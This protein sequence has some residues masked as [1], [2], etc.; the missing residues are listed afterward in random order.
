VA[1][2]CLRRRAAGESLTDDQILAA[3]PDIAAELAEELA[4]ARLIGQARRTADE[5]PTMSEASG[6]PLTS[7]AG[8]AGRGTSA[9]GDATAGQAGRG[10]PPGAASDAE[11]EGLPPS[12]FKV[13]GYSIIR[14]ISRGGQAVVFEAL[15]ESTGRK[16]AVKVLREGPFL[17]AR[18]RARFDREVQI[19]AAL[20]HP[21]IVSIIDRGATEHGAQY[22][23]MDYIE[24]RTLDQYLADYRDKHGDAPLDPSQML[25]LFLKI[26]DAVNAAHL[27]GIV[28]RDLKPS[29]IRIDGRGEPHILDFGLA[30]VWAVRSLTD[31]SVPQPVTLTGQFLGSLPWA[32]PEQAEGLPDKIDIRSDVYSLGVVLYQMLTGGHFPYEVA[33]TMR[34]VL[35]NIITVAPTPPSQMIEAGLARKMRGRRGRFRRRKA[36][37][38]VIEAIVLKSLAKGP[39]QRYQS[40]GDFARDIGNYLSGQPTIAAGMAALRRQRRSRLVRA[41]AVAGGIVAACLL[42]AVVMLTVILPR[43]FAPALPEAPRGAEEAALAAR[44]A[45]VAAIF[46]D[47]D[48]FTVPTA[49]LGQL[50]YVGIVRK[51]PGILTIGQDGILRLW[52]VLLENERRR[53]NLDLPRWWHTGHFCI[54]PDGALGFSTEDLGR[55]LERS[56]NLMN[57]AGH[58]W[59]LARGTEVK[60]VSFGEDR[61]DRGPTLGF[62][63]DGRFVLSVLMR[64]PLGNWLAILWNANT[65]EQVAKFR[66]E[67]DVFAFSQDMRLLVLGDGTRDLPDRLRAIDL[68]TRQ[69][70]KQFKGHK[71]PVGSAAVSPDGRFILGGGAASDP[72][73][74]QWDAATGDIVRRFEGHTGDVTAVAMSADGRWVLSSSAADSDNTLRIWDAQTGREVRRWPDAGADEI[75]LPPDRPWAMT[76]RGVTVRLYRLPTE[77]PTTATPLAPPT[78]PA[79]PVP[80]P[81]VAPPNTLTDAEKA[82]GWRLLFDGKTLAGWRVPQKNDLPTAWSVVDGTLFTDRRVVPMITQDQFDNFEL[83]LEWKI[84]GDGE[85]VLTYRATEDHLN[86]WM[87][88]PSVSLADDEGRD[89]KGSSVRW[90]G[91]CH[92]LYAPAQK[93]ARPAG[94]WNR[95]RVVA[96]GNKVEHWVNGVK[97]LEYE[98]GSE[99]FRQRLAK[100]AY[101]E[102]WAGFGTAPRGHIGLCSVQPVAV[103]FRNIKIRPLGA[104]PAAAAPPSAVPETL[105]GPG[106]WVDVLALVDPQRDTV[107]GEWQRQG[108]T[109][110]VSLPA[111]KWGCVVIPVAPGGDYELEVRFVRLSGQDEVGVSLPVGDAA[112]NFCLSE[113]GGVTGGLGFINGKKICDTE[114]AVNPSRLENGREYVVHVKVASDGPNATIEVA[115]DGKPYTAWRG[116]RAAL[117]RD[118]EKRLPRHNCLGLR[119][120]GSTVAFF[121]ARLRML[122]GAAMLLGSPPAAAPAPAA[123]SQMGPTIGPGQWVDLL[124]LVDPSADA[125]RGKWER[126]DGFLL[127]QGGWY[128]CL[129]LPVVVDGSYE[130]SVSA[131]DPGGKAAYVMVLLPVGASCTR[132]QCGAF[133]RSPAL[134]AGPKPAPE[135][136]LREAP[137]AGAEC[138]ADVKVVTDRDQGEI[139]ALT[140]GKPGLHWK[141]RQADLGVEALWQP[142]RP[143][144]PGLCAHGEPVLYTSAKLRMLS[145]EARLLRP[146]PDPAAK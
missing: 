78:T 62:S 47:K 61:S 74:I 120:V 86:P 125:T 19:L 109:V 93:A 100:W 69:E 127:A 103:A 137:V 84:A 105:V 28:H 124:A 134:F 10:K 129:L 106:Q 5:A 33:G 114:T 49:R 64:P 31:E 98:L 131:R 91:G 55:T 36:V 88:G 133:D 136:L 80:P 143:F 25:R 8:Q 138:R 121:S 46:G 115:L 1:E 83:D 141:G 37:N 140:D 12:S 73:V 51:G 90:S 26:A 50:R 9:E 118:E 117:S 11:G 7:T 101:G 60:V 126:R 13:P 102:I 58:F 34:D 44:E 24:G 65:G 76:R 38:E 14:E 110:S 146:P 67:R 116:P 56:G 39:E 23:V 89:V 139:T 2:E 32:S 119:A 82:A 22:L 113:N 85:S 72:V 45:E 95:T 43:Y 97:V 99:D 79:P 112:V 130:L 66:S 3:H 75:Y 41:A 40:A 54:S 108:P 63:P 77:L 21:N 48:V 92:Y 6:P 104:A 70:V 16:V 71:G 122:S 35:N 27:R 144:A 142:S 18:Q 111:S 145:G 128:S 29:N 87:T 30:A 68:A 17:T 15:Q 42:T 81:A 52:D 123:V 4:K 107:S 132:F 96:V 53:A 94:Q 59:D 135:I 57:L 20:K